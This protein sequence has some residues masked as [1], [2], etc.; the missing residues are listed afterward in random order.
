M[1]KRI[2]TLKKCFNC[3]KKINIDTKLNYCTYHFCENCINS[4]LSGSIY[5]IIHD[6][7]QNCAEELL[8]R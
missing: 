7:L 4:W 1:P 8:V 6:C 5:E 3:S 2:S